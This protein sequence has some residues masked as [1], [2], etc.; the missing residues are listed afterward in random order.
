[1]DTKTPLQFQD[2]PVPVA[3]VADGGRP[4]KCKKRRLLRAVGFS[5]LC[6]W[7]GARYVHIGAPGSFQQL[8]KV[9]PIPSD[10]SIDHCAEWSDISETDADEPFPYSAATSFELPVSADTLFLLSRSVGRGVFATGRVN[11]VQSEDVSDSVQVDITARFWHQD[12]LDAAKTCLLTRDGDQSGVGIFTKWKGEGHRDRHDKMRFEVTVTLPQAADDGILSINN[13][14]TDFQIFTQIFG[15]M[16]NVAFK[17]L[18]L[19]TSLGGI[20]AESLSTGNASLLTSLGPIRLQS[21]TAESATIVTSM[22]P[23]EGTFNATNTLTLSTA[24]GPIIVDVNLANAADAPAKLRMHTSNGHI[25]GTITLLSSK[26]ADASTAFDLIARSSN[27]RMA[28]AVLAAPLGANI[29]L[30]ATTSIGAVALR[31]PATYEGTFGASTSLAGLSVKVD[32]EAEDPA[33]EGRKRRVEWTQTGRGSAK[34]RVGWSEEG[35]GRGSVSVRT[36]LAPVTL[37]L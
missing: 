26:D 22:G 32:E 19:R 9:W 4:P 13:L 10:V 24:N 8:G 2:L 30:R 36:S 25:N 12:H 23:I 3:H 11:Y 31:L 15:D 6:L 34:G 7:L 16:S 20:I 37:E 1:M 14:S 33:G 35:M 21:L 5:A 27:A 28:L 17:S 29:T 18:S